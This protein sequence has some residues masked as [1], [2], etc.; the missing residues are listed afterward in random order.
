MRALAAASLAG[1][2]VGLVVGGVGGRLAMGLL[3]RLNPEDAGRI[4][5]DGFRIGQLTASGTLNLLGAA[6]QAGLTGALLYL[7]LRRLALGAPAVRVASLT[8]GGAVV[9]GAFLVHPQGRDF[10]ILGPDWLPVLLFVALP[11][12]FV[13][14]LALLAERW[15]APGSWF[16]TARLRYV[17][18]LLL[19]WVLAGLLLPL[20]GLAVVVG[21]VHQRLA[22]TLS[23][24]ARAAVAWSA[25]VL[26][27]ALGLWALWG[28][29]GAV[30]A[31]T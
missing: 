11:A 5:D 30:R 26:L 15:L 12:V 18:P 20:L 21:L 28:L 2:V 13:P 27:V 4:T 22:P 1:A 19:V 10:R 25:R 3:A 16:A 23:T 24:G 6:V 29:V 31:V 9:V 17:A 8:L 7:A 14:L